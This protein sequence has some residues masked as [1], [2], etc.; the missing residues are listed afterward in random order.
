MSNAKPID[1][2]ILGANVSNTADRPEDERRSI[3]AELVACEDKA[4]A[5]ASK[6]Y[7]EDFGLPA[8]EQVKRIELRS[9][10]ANP[11][12]EA[13]EDEI[14]AERQL[15]KEEESLITNEGIEM[16]WPPLGDN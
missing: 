16:R 11:L 1:I 6:K 3:F 7:P 15:S 13:C 8:A 9:A 5:E 12:R 2:K 14:R 4:N 10:H